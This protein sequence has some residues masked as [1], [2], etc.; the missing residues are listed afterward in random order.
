MNIPEGLV[1]LINS[2][3]RIT[4]LSTTDADGTP[5]T[6][7]IGSAFM[8]E[9]DQVWIGLGDNRTSKNLRTGR[10]AVLL[11]IRPGKSVLDWKGGRLY[12]ELAA[13]ETEGARF[14]R[15]IERIKTTAGR[16]AARSIRH[17]AICRI[18]EV[19]PLAELGGG[20]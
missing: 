3:G 9:E 19:R 16:L 12:L 5:D 4:T 20:V 14:D 15:M 11:V 17:L 10:K 7:I 2:P 13:L 1:E 6:A 8:A 18:S